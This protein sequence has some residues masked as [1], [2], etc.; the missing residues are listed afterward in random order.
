MVGINVL[1]AYIDFAKP[2]SGNYQIRKS[3]KAGSVEMQ[4]I[5]PDQL[6]GLSQGYWQR[7]G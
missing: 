5:T 6:G 1:K 2:P 7:L 3:A 4:A